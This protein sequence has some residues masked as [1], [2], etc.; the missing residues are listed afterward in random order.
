MGSIVLFDKNKRYDCKKCTDKNFIVGQGRSMEFA[1]D[2]IK[3]RL[4]AKGCVRESKTEVLRLNDGRRIYRCPRAIFETSGAESHYKEF[5]QLES[6]ALTVDA[7]Q[8]PY[9]WHTIFG[10]VRHEILLCRKLE[11]KNNSS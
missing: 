11:I 6:G 9:K 4:R 3:R 1:E 8:R 2:K 7:D 5:I 10:I